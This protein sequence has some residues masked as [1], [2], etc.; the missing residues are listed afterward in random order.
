MSRPLRLPKP[1]SPLDFYRQLLREASYLPP[2]ARGF[3]DEQIKRRFRRN[4]HDEPPKTL[5]DVGQARH[6]LRMLRAANAGD[7]MRMQ[8]VLHI[9]FGR[10]GRRRRELSAR[11]VARTSPAT[12]DDSEGSAS[13][14]AAEFRKTDWLD[15][16]DMPK[17]H[18]FANSQ[19][20]AGLTSSPRPPLTNN[21]TIEALVIPP[22]NA[23]GQ[24]L[25]PRLLRKKR[26]TMWK[27]VADKCMPPLPLEEWMKLK[28]IAEG[29]PQEPWLPPPR[30]PAAQAVCASGAAAKGTL[31]AWNW[32]SY[33]VRPVATVDR[34]AN[35][36][37][38][39][40]TGAVD[41]NTPTGDPQ[42]VDCHK[43]TPRFW[44]RL[45]GQ[46]WQLTPIMERKGTRDSDW[47]IVWGKQTFQPPPTPAA[48]MGFFTDFPPPPEPMAVPNRR[49]KKGAA[50]HKT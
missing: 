6:D 23:W 12:G 17:L 39:L 25:P 14:A 1:E 35:R 18:T 41:D 16:W 4:R 30:R 48:A 26:M 31:D 33:A 44:R 5:R 10:V 19:V 15:V 13:A 2:L 45:F 49:R 20:L 28:A 9:A 50:A 36:K 38:K 34:S 21:Q 27:S 46:L 37:N 43:Y 24:P 11:L 29:T 8:R 7:M 22:E 3:I 42:P 40:L 47:R 32:R